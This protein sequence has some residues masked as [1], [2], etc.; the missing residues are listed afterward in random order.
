[1]GVIEAPFTIEEVIDNS[2]FNFNK[3]ATKCERF[4]KIGYVKKNQS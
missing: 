4:S 1:M 2:L 3:S